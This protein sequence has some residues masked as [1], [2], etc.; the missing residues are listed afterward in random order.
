MFLVLKLSHSINLSPSAGTVARET[1]IL[2]VGAPAPCLRS[3]TTGKFGA[4]N[5]ALPLKLTLTKKSAPAGRRI[6]IWRV[7]WLLLGIRYTALLDPD[8]RA[9]VMV[10]GEDS[11]ANALVVPA[12]ASPV[13]TRHTRTKQT[14][15][16]IILVVYIVTLPGIADWSWVLSLKPNTLRVQCVEKYS[17]RPMFK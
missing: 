3:D 6:D 16:Q 14:P 5:S 11:A 2:L 10:S 15:T 1:E 8:S 12:R 17:G 9:Y 4:A 7:K 13:S